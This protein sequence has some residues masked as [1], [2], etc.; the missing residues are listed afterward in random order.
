MTQL[1]NL[2]ENVTEKIFKVRIFKK[3][4]SVAAADPVYFKLNLRIRM[5]DVA[6]EKSDP[7][8]YPSWCSF[9]MMVKWAN[10]GLLQVNDGKMLVNVGEM[11][12]NDGEMLVNDGEMLVNEGE[13]LN[14]GEILVNDGETLVNDGEMLVNDGEMSVWSFTHFTIIDQLFTI[15]NEHFIIISLKLTN[16]AHLRLY[17][18][19][20]KRSALLFGTEHC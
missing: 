18:C 16:I 12:V 14:E 13:M 7:V 11:L 17:P 19:I 15:I 20:P 9:S 6:S 10:D 2:P 1:D 5:L 3:K 4:L 8:P